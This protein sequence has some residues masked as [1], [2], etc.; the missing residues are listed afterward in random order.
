LKSGD[1]LIRDQFVEHFALDHG[2]TIV[3]VLDLYEH[4]SAGN[5]YTR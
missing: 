4:A 3:G 2:E 5:R 1:F